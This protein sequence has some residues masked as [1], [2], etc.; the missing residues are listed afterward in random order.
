MH[1]TNST[2]D[3]D[4]RVDRHKSRERVGSWKLEVKAAVMVEFVVLS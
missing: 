4:L 3:A 2:E 1:A